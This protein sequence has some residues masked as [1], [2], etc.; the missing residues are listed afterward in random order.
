MLITTSMWC[1][2]RITVMP[3]S[4]ILRMMRDQLL[5]VGR[6][7]AGGRLV[8][9]QQLRVERQ[10]ARDLEQPLLAVRQVARLLVR[11]VGQADEAA[12]G[13][14]RAPR[15]ARALA[16]VARR[17][18]GHVEQVAAKV[19]CRPT[20]HVLQ[21]RHLAEQLHVL[22]GARDARQRDVRRRAPDQRCARRSRSRRR[23][24]RRC[25]SARSSSCSCP[26][27]SARSGRGSCRA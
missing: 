3:C 8:E 10:R 4:R 16:P 15:A 22:E 25:R 26:S 18:H 21:R 9:Q 2:I 14:A 12:A 13:P 1:S 6:G 19:W 17:V 7:Q 24:A 5:D 23:S 27:R 20:M 11:E